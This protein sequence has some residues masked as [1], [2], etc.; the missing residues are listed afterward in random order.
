MCAD[1]DAKEVH[2][3]GSVFEVTLEPFQKDSSD[4]L[5]FGAAGFGDDQCLKLLP[6]RGISQNVYFLLSRALVILDNSGD[7][8]DEDARMMTARSEL[9]Q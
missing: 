6:S 2:L 7:H 8:D 4:A 3:L 1:A 5:T 9:T